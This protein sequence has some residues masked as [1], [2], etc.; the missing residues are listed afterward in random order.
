VVD[1]FGSFI[2]SGDLDG[3]LVIGVCPKLVSGFSFGS[4][5]FDGFDGFGV[6]LV[7]LSKIDSCLGQDFFVIGDGLFK[8]FNGV[9]CFGD[10]R[11]EGGDGFVTVDLIG[12]VC[13]FS[14]V[15]LLFKVFNDLVNDEH[16]FV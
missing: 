4:S 6:I 7:G 2:K 10:L 8:I 11:L 5:D 1:Q 13:F 15:F 3:H 9:R 14:C 12:L 16:D